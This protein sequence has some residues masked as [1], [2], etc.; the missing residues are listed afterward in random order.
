[1]PRPGGGRNIYVDVTNKPDLGRRQTLLWEG[2]EFGTFGHVVIVADPE[3]K[4][5]PNRKICFNAYEPVAADNGGQLEKVGIPQIR[6]R[7]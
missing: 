4:Y 6:V 2:R 3:N 5:A 7:E 1:M